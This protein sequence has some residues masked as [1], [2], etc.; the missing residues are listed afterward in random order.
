MALDL[1]QLHAAPAL[2]LSSPDRQVQVTIATKEKLEPYPS[3]DR[4]YYSVTYHGKEIVLDSPLG[5][6]FKEMGPLSRDLIIKKQ[7]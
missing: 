4:M 5:L 7:S 1:T 6:D 2:V 3:G